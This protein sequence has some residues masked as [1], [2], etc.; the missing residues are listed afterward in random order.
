MSE[1]TVGVHDVYVAQPVVLPIGETEVRTWVNTKLSTEPLIGRHVVGVV[2]LVKGWVVRQRVLALNAT[3][4]IQD[5]SCGVVHMKL[6]EGADL[7]TQIQT[8]VREQHFARNTTPLCRAPQSK[9]Q[10]MWPKAHVRLG[11]PLSRVFRCCELDLRLGG[12][13]SELGCEIVCGRHVDVHLLVKEIGN[14]LPCAVG[15]INRWD[16]LGL[17]LLQQ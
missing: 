4:L 6:I 17:V 12:D 10:L 16:W 2:F 13:L 3:Y 7:V 1:R 5:L 14:A 11:K 8:G 9:V 15:K